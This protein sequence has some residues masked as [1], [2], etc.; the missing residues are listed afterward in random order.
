M[1]ISRKLTL[2]VCVVGAGQ[3]GATFAYALLIRGLAAEIVLI[4]ANR[5]LAEG[6]AKDLSHGLPYVRPAHVYAGDYSDCCGADIV[7]VTAGAAQKPGETRLDLTKRNVAIFRKI[8]PQVHQYAP[9]AIVVIVSNPV[10]ILTYASLKFSGYPPHRVIGSGTTLDSARFRF[11]LSQHCGVDPRNVHAYIIGEHGDSEVPVWSLAHI[12]GTKVD[13]YCRQCEKE[14]APIPKDEIFEQVRTA[15]Y[16]LIEKKDAMYH[17][18]GLA[19]LTIMESIVRAQN[20][21]LSVS[22]LMSDYHGISDVCLSVPTV[23]NR[24]GVVQ[25]IDLPLNNAEKKALRRS[26]TILKNIIQDVGLRG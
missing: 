16:H 3:V 7:V 4:D 24:Q 2:K 14:C 19:A 9:D 12:A 25:Q 20:S 18:I 26:A 17:A 1:D 23:L 6:Q 22:T 10:D 21:V 8:I 5:A 15:A 11:L 13:D